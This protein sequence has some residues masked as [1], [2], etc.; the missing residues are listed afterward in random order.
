MTDKSYGE[1]ASEE[2]IEKTKAALEA[3]GFN[4]VV[5]DK[6][7][8]AKTAVLDMVDEGAEVFTAASVTLA[9]TGLADELNGNKYVSVRNKFMA[10]YGQQDKAKEMRQIGSVSDFALGSVHAITEEGQVLVASA[11]GSQ[12]PNYVYGATKVI[13]V[14]GSQK[15]VSNMN[16]AFERLET[17]TFAL[18][19]ARALVAYGKHSSINDVFIMRKD[20]A[21]RVTI[22]IIREAIGF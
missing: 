5:V 11:S 16:H 20:L 8:D 18:E 13:W 10:L 6:P 12:I 14:V 2:S 4:V 22:V 15:I 1:K 3:N 17:H 7:L 9:E 19:D 21:S